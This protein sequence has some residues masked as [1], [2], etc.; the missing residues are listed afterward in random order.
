MGAIGWIP[1][2]PAD[3]FE[4]SFQAHYVGGKPYSPKVYDHNVRQ[5]HNYDS[6]DLNSARY[7]SYFLVDIM[8]QKRF[9]YDRMNLIMFFGILNVFNR[10][11]PQ[12]YAY[13]E[14][15]TQEIVL[16]FKRIPSGGVR[17]EF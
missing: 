13:L 11:N 16:Q 2:A 4:F 8:F 7:D 1:F 3:E 15:G 9:Y 5:W 17:L 6:Q 14:D 12:M 10:E